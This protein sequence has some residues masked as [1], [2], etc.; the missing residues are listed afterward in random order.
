MPRSVFQGLLETVPG[1]V[2]LQDWGGALSTL[3]Q[4]LDR[5]ETR[6]QCLRVFE[7]WCSVPS[8]VQ[9]SEAWRVWSARILYRAGEPDRCRDFLELCGEDVRLEGFWAWVALPFEERFRRGSAALDA[10]N[11]EAR[12]ASMVWRSR[13]MAAWCAGREDWR[14]AFDVALAQL[15]GRQRGLCFLELGAVL[16]KEGDDGAARAAYAHS[17]PLLETDRYWAAHVNYNIATTCLRLN[18]LEEAARH[19]QRA[20]VDAQSPEA[21]G[22]RSRAWSGLGAVQRARRQMPRALWSYEQARVHATAKD[23]RVQAL[24]V[25]RIRCGC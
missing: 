12:D 5:A 19:A 22:F 20:W 11:L 18:Q 7:V 1:L 10:G 25:L 2:R 13:A 14:V 24:E 15:E 4:A 17:L 8:G 3:R 16:T 21:S 6:A 23:D 9:T